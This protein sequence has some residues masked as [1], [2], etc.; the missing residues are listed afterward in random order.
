MGLLTISEAAKQCGVSTQT[1]LNWGNRGIITIKK[2]TG[3]S[4]RNW[5]HVDKEQI[6]AICSV[7]QDI[8]KTK[9]A[10][11]EDGIELMAK[12]KEL[13]EEIQNVRNELRLIRTLNNVTSIKDFFFSAVCV[14][15]KLGIISNREMTIIQQLLDGQ[16]IHNIAMGLGLSEQRVLQIYGRACR[17]IK[18]DTL[19]STLV[20]E[21]NKLK[22]DYN[23][24][25]HC[26][27]II[28]T[29]NAKLKEAFGEKAKKQNA[30][31][32]DERKKYLEETD[33]ICRLFSTDISDITYRD[34]YGREKALSVRA[35]NC[36]KSSNLRTVGD[37]ASL[38]KTKLLKL[39]NLGKKV[40][41]EIDDLFSYHKISFGTNIDELYLQRAIIHFGL[42]DGVDMVNVS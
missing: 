8:G 9:K 39:R 36:L 14:F 6:D 34:F 19:L 17:K 7:A 29:E 30:I 32:I 1:I 3:K 22:S 21:N 11:E 16:C 40:L 24:L 41:T 27:C 10:I 35:I 38:T 5:F 28:E 12:H 4:G 23:E 42:Y 33:D 25:K 13:Q 37:I 18:K 2:I 26:Y 20:E 15:E 31:T